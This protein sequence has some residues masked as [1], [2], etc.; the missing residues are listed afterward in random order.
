MKKKL[1]FG[2]IIAAMLMASGCQKQVATITETNT[3]STMEEATPNEV[4]FEES[5]VAE[6][7]ETDADPD[8]EANYKNL[9]IDGKEISLPVKYQDFVD[10]G[11]TDMDEIGDT[12][13]EPEFGVAITWKN[14]EGNSFTGVIVNHTT[15]TTNVKDGSVIAILSESD[16]ENPADITFYKGISLNSTEEEIA[17]VLTLNAKEDGVS[18]YYKNIDYDGNQELYAKVVDGKVTSVQLYAREE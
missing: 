17:S 5:T 16:Y 8:F 4:V 11:Y 10:M 7:D 15:E 9:T 1:M 12:I 14:D 18:T 3:K 2:I 13:L 6:Y